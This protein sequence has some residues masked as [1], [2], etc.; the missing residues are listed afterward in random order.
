MR[1]SK[2]TILLACVML[3]A[4]LSGCGSSPD[5]AGYINAILDNTFRNDSTKFV[6]MKIGTAEQAAQAYETTLAGEADALIKLSNADTASDEQRAQIENIVKDIFAKTKY[7]VNGAEKQDDG[8]YVVTVTYEQLRVYGNALK[9]YL[10]DA[11]R[12]SGELSEAVEKPSEDEL[13]E[14]LLT[15]YIDDFHD[16]LANVTYDEPK[17][18]E[19]RVELNNRTWQV[20]SA[21]FTSFQQNL[22]DLTDAIDDLSE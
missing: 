14:T 16:A 13:K 18:A 20:N 10:A 7:T 19:I 3:T 2:L 9:A 22:F 21:D 5:M 6:E 1:K 4:F 11:M 15:C 12:I 17:T 8:S